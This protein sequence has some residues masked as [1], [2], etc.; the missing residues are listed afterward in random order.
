MAHI[1]YLGRDD[2]VVGKALRYV[3]AMLGETVCYVNRPRFTL[4]RGVQSLR[5]DG[6]EGVEEVDKQQKE[7]NVCVRTIA[8]FFHCRSVSPQQLQPL[9]RFC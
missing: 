3:V 7:I 5:E 6:N 8:K 1:Q 2:S 4:M 9:L